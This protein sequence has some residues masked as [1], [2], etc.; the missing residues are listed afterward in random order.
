MQR[1]SFTNF[2]QLKAGDI[3][4]AKSFQV[5]A[6]GELVCYVVIPKGEDL[7]KGHLTANLD[8]LVMVNN[9]FGGKEIDTEV[10]HDR[11]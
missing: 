6:D 8:E 7:I 4:E 10:S 3:K 5:T 11:F 9:S 2:K 1:I